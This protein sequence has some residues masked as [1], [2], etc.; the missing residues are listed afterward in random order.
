MLSERTYKKGI[1]DTS[2]RTIM[3]NLNLIISVHTKSAFWSETSIN[4]T[5]CR[6]LDSFLEEENQIAFWKNKIERV[7]G[8]RNQEVMIAQIPIAPQN[9]KARQQTPMSLHPS[10]STLDIQ[11]SMPIARINR[12]QRSSLHHI[13]PNS[14]YCKEPIRTL[15]KIS[16]HIRN[17][18]TT[19]QGT[20]LPTQENKGELIG[21]F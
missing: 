17:K 13:K 16:L 5:Y 14:N 6:K 3:M 8:S 10:Q 21:M 7:T 9:P 1:Q 18:R 19:S 11:A 20:C 12:I 4:L 2:K 15:Q